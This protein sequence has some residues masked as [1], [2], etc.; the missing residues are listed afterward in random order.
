MISGST[1]SDRVTSGG[2]WQP[3]AHAGACRQAARW[4]PSGSACGSDTSWVA[5]PTFAAIV[6]FSSFSLFSHSTVMVP[7]SCRRVLSPFSFCVQLF[8]AFRSF[9]PVNEAVAVV[10]KTPHS[11]AHPPKINNNLAMKDNLEVMK[12]SRKTL[13][14]LFYIHMAF[15]LLLYARLRAP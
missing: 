11:S 9:R 10:I 1:G 7:S 5:A 12:S 6:L 2:A 14:N 3:K 4:K 13:F 15:P 8:S